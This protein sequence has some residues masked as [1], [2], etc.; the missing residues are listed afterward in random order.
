MARKFPMAE[1]QAED[2]E[3]LFDRMSNGPM[4]PGV[5]PRTYLDDSPRNSNRTD[6]SE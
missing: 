2:E 5:T 6:Q 1:E 4:T 3:A